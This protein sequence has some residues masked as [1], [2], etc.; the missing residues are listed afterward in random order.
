MAEEKGKPKGRMN[1]YALFLQSMRADHKKKHPN[2]TLDFK[3]FSK[4][5]SEQWKNL[6]AKEKKKFKDLAEK[7]KERYRCEMEHYEP[8]ADE[9]RSKKRKR[10]PDAPKKG[11]SAFFLFCN[12]ERPK[13]KSE[14]PDWKVS[15]VAKELGR[16]WEHCKN[17]AKYESL[18][19]VEKERYEKAM[20]K[21]KAGKKP[22]TE[23]SESDD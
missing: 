20:E 11:L 7:D 16:R 13:V 23:D 4:E 19:Q 8:P 21:Y 17:K 22:K 3:S 10:D 2:A 1:A 6:S 14:N 18:A 15:E 12:D 5:C 9:G